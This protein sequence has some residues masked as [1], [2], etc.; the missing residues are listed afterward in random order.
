MMNIK[1][2]ICGSLLLLPAAGICPM[3]RADTGSTGATFTSLEPVP[4]SGPWFDPGDPGTGFF[5]QV[6][7]GTLV[8]TYFGF[9]QDGNDTWLLFSGALVPDTSHLN[10]VWKVEADLLRFSGGKCIIDCT[11]GQPDNAN[12]TNQS[13]GTIKV[14]IMGRSQARFS[15]DG[16]PMQDIVPLLFGVPGF[17]EFPDTSPMLLPVLTGKWVGV[18]THVHQNVDPD[19]AQESYSFIMDIGPRTASGSGADRVVEY[20]ASRTDPMDQ[21]L[22]TTQITCGKASCEMSISALMSDST[23]VDTSIEFRNISGSR[24]TAEEAP[25]IV[26]SPPPPKLRFDAFRVGYD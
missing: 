7:N 18:L 12:E 14:E 24:L 22:R 13:V 8:G 23:F 1:M 9:D 16:G 2:L 10:V 11:G 4:E 21:T 25:G 26:G 17:V 6:Q 19:V 3:S 15:I 20:T 5:W